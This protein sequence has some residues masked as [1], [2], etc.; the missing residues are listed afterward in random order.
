MARAGDRSI[1][2][3]AGELAIPEACL[4]DWVADAI[5]EDG[6][7][8]RHPSDLL[9]REVAAL[10]REK[11]RLEVENEIL[12]RAAVHFARVNALPATPVPSPDL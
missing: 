6:V 11:R 1:A 3:L 12:K 4:W 8:D 5:A 2:V 10:R 7:P 9:R